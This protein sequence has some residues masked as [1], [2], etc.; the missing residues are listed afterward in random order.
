MMRRQEVT[1]GIL[2]IYQCPTRAFNKILTRN[3]DFRVGRVP[4]KPTLLPSFLDCLILQDV[5]RRLASALL[6]N[7]GFSFRQAA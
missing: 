3:R 7:G 1:A 6:M 2:D 5:E 4:L